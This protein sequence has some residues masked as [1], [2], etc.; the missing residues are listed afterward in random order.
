MRRLRSPPPP[1]RA[2]LDAAGKTTILYKLHIG[3]VLSTVPTIGF[4]VEKV[5]VG[6]GAGGVVAGGCGAACGHAPCHAS[7]LPAPAVTP[8]PLMM[9]LMAQLIW[10]PHPAPGLPALPACPQVQYKNVVFTVWD[11]G[12]QEKLRPLWRHYFNNTDALIYVVDCCDRERVGR[13]ASEFKVRG[14]VAGGQGGGGWAAKQRWGRS[15][16]AKPIQCS[17]W[18]AVGAGISSL[19]PPPSSSS[20]LPIHT[21]LPAAAP[22]R[23]SAPACPAPVP[24]CSK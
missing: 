22:A 18:Q 6:W 10:P 11:V 23:P 7:L 2:G 8:S 12:G 19:Q 16:P 13:A 20:F 4:N 5:G 9:Q 14:T 3:E 24:A 21:C 17:G 15:Q 1:L